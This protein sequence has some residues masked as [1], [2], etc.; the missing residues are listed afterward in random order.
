MPSTGTHSGTKF[1]AIG[2]SSR[3]CAAP[4]STSG[5]PPHTR[6]QQQPRCDRAAANHTEDLGV[7]APEVREPARGPAHALPDGGH[8]LHRGEAVRATP[9]GRGPKPRGAIGPCTCLGGHGRAGGA[10]NCDDLAA[11]S[12]PHR[13]SPKSRGLRGSGDLCCFCCFCHVRSRNPARDERVVFG[14][15]ASPPLTGRGGVLL[16]SPT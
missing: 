16:N 5:V 8:G 2:A 12:T 10:Q 1:R 9:H 3:P 11:P 13:R 6:S 7:V 14:V 4:R 15:R